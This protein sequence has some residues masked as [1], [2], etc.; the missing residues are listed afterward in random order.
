[1]NPTEPGQL[2]E[3]SHPREAFHV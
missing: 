3:A 2:S 1:L